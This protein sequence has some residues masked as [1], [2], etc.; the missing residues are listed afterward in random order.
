MNQTHI[1]LLITHLP[2]FGSMIGAFVLLYGIF[3]KSIQTKTA[4]YLVLILSSLG[5]FRGRCRLSWCYGILILQYPIGWLTV[6]ILLP[7]NT[8]L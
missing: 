2:I 4:A 6:L 3:T 8:F 7:H 5:R 1:H